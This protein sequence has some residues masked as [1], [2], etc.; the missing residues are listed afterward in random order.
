MRTFALDAPFRARALLLRGRAGA[1]ATGAH[2]LARLQAGVAVK[3]GDAP[4]AITGARE[5][6]EAAVTDEAAEG[7]SVSDAGP[8][9][10]ESWMPLRGGEPERGRCGAPVAADGD[11]D[12]EADTD[13]GAAVGVRDGTLEAGFGGATMRVSHVRV[14]FDARAPPGAAALSTLIL[15]RADGTELVS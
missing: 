2:A 1:G 10:F 15:Y 14:Q 7:D 4:C 12:D 6:P 5:L 3:L 11:A 13:A 8:A 9:D